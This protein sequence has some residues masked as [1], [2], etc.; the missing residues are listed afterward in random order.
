MHNLVSIPTSPCPHYT[1]AILHAPES[2]NSDFKQ[3]LNNYQV[4]SPY[5]FASLFSSI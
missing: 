1:A 3:V 5:L 4:S 2:Q